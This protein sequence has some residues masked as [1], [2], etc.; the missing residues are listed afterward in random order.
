MLGVLAA[1]AALLPAAR[2]AS[3][4]EWRSRSIYQV[5]TDRFASPAS[6]PCPSLSDYCGGTWD[7]LA[8]HL[9]YIQDLGFDALWVSPVVDNA[10]G[11]YH[12]YWQRDMYSANAHF[13]NWS[14]LRALA[15]ALHA[16]DMLLM[17]DV[18]A[19]HA[20]TDADVSQNAPFNLT[21]QYHDCAGCPASCQVED[22]TDHAQMEHC[23]LAGLR[24]FDNT[25]E[26]GAVAAQLYAWVAFLVNASGADG[27]RV[28][29]TPY[30]RPAFW[31]RFE[32]S[33]GVYAVGEV[34]TGDLAFAAPYQGA[35]LSGILSYPLFFVLRAVFQGRGSMRQLGDA[36]RAGAAAWQDLGLL[37][38]FADNHDNPRFLS[39]QGD[40]GL[41]R[42]ALAYAL[43]SDGIPITY[44]GS[45]WLLR[46]GADP[47][48][49]EA[50]WAAAGGG[51]P[52]YSAQAAPLGP[53]LAA[54]NAHRRRAALWGALQVERWQDD[55]FYAFSRGSSTLAVFTNAGSGSGRQAR[56]VTYLPEAWAPG[57]RLCDALDCSSCVVVGAGP[58]ARVS[59]DGASGVAVYSPLVAPC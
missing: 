14:S 55:G 9:D 10:P 59:V 18:V 46:G 56:D 54:L 38:V 52:P 26:A 36:W 4:D 27:L 44:Y 8:Q 50:L 43:L 35:A 37:G 45:E 7:A 19:N 12:G 24:D 48:C 2:A 33:A 51:A 32:R 29:T 22:F 31:Q 16:R 13:G 20:S 28:D 34:D 11:G 21:S 57:T 41:F 1:A 53:F 39:S 17:V 42:A 58:V 5:L 49:R 6:A 30:V 40:V 3:P 23:R 47:G 25:D 15:D